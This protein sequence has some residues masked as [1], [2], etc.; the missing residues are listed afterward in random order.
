MGRDSQ[1]IDPERAASIIERYEGA[2]V[3][4]S[5]VDFFSRS[6]RDLVRIVKMANAELY[7]GPE[8]RTGILA[9]VG[10]DFFDYQ[11]KGGAI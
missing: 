8:G 3:A 4:A 9:R 5:A 6:R 7:K 10:L 1:Y 11:I 2:V